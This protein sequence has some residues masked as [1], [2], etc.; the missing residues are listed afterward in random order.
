MGFAQQ[1]VV[2]MTS[3][4]CAT[5]GVV[6]W[7]PDEMERQRRKDGCTFYCPN[8]HTNVYA[9]TEADRLRKDKAAL[10]S[11]LA[12]ARTATSREWERA[13]S[14]ENKAAKLKRKVDCVNRGVCPYCRRSFVALTRHV[15]CQ[16][17]GE[18]K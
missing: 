6:F 14:A 8:G 12:A 2:T 1:Q 15:A 11:Q 18:V 9:V 3:C 16:H 13:N 7:W 10:E 5:C 17:A 4:L